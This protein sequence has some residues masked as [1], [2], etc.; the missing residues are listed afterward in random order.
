MALEASDA[1]V[2]GQ[3]QTILAFLAMRA[4][5]ECAV[6]ALFTFRAVFRALGAAQAI[7]AVTAIVEFL[8][9]ALAFGAD[10]AGVMALV[11]LQAGRA[12]VA[13]GTLRADTEAFGADNAITSGLA[14]SAAHAMG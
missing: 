4:L 13:S 11:A 6:I 8:H 7:L 14:R 5:I 3:S 1:E 10:L 9:T 2:A 12:P